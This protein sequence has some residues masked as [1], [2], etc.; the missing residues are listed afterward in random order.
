[1]ERKHLKFS[2]T[3]KN[4]WIRGLRMCRV[5]PENPLHFLIKGDEYASGL[6]GLILK[7][8]YQMITINNYQYYTTLK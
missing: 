6:S 1:M 5:C 3:I 2:K 8:S 7:L 4:N